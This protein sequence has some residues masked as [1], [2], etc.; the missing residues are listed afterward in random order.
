MA[1]NLRTRRLKKDSQMGCCPRCQRSR[2]WFQS[3]TPSPMGKTWV[4]W[5]SPMLR[6]KK[7]FLNILLQHM[8]NNKYKTSYIKSRWDCAQGPPM[9]PGPLMPWSQSSRQHRTPMTSSLQSDLHWVPQNAL[10]RI[11]ANTMLL[12]GMLTGWFQYMHL[13]SIKKML[14][15]FWNSCSFQYIPVSDQHTI[16]DRDCARPHLNLSATIHI[17]WCSNPKYSLLNLDWF[18]YRND[19]EILHLC[20]RYMLYI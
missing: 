4:E 17:I 13:F 11:L 9:R 8:F 19:Y 7:T 14:F 16:P 15:A 6:K 2:I 10:L 1:A 12:I 18:I 20:I 5:R 3:W